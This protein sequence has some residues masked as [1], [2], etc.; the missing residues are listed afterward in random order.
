[1][2]PVVYGL[3][4]G[5]VGRNGIVGQTADNEIYCHAGSALYAIIAGYCSYHGHVHWIFYSVAVMS[6]ASLILLLSIDPKKID[7]KAARG[8]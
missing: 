2:V 5:M 4:L 8:L 3:T 7:N 6:G 1:M